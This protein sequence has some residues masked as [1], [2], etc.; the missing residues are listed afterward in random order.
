MKAIVVEHH[1]SIEELRFREHTPLPELAPHQIRVQTAYCGLNHLDIWLRKGGTGDKLTLPRIPGSDVVGIVQEVGQGVRKIQVGEA[2]LLYPGQGCGLCPACIA[3]R[4]TMCPEFQIRGYHLDGGYAEYVTVEEQCALPIPADQLKLWAGVPVSYVT[5]W[6]ALVTKGQLKPIDAVVIW[7]ASGGLGYAALSI[8]Q[9]FGA[10]VIGIVGSKNKATFLQE[11]GFTGDIIIR[12]EDLLE[13]IKQLTH[14]RGVDLVLD[15]VGKQTWNISLKMLT[16]GGRLAFCGITSGPK[17]ETDLRYI[18]GKQLSI[19]GSW[20]GDHQDFMEVVQ[21]LKQH[22][23][24]L[25]YIY[26]EFPLHDAQEAQATLE[27]GDHVGKVVLNVSA[28]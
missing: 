12:S 5:A 8:A 15:H 14:K 11:Q 1:G 24:A 18:F 23:Q 28:S 17:V 10:K 2:V 20:M 6:N 25:P 16:K 7:G 13:E 22:P 19:F 26:K 27:Q 4:E 9:A 3:G 21:F